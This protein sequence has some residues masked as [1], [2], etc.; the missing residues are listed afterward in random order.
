MPLRQKV[1]APSC[2]PLGVPRTSPTVRAA[3]THRCG[4]GTQQT[5]PSYV[6]YWQLLPAWPA[7]AFAWK[8]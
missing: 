3:E 1:L 8:V 4:E 6:G 2:S 5:L 7:R